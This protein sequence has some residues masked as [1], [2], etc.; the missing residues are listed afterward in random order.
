MDLLSNETINTVYITA[1]YMLLDANYFKAVND[2]PMVQ[3]GKI[4]L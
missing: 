2:L 1:I 3:Q 4:K